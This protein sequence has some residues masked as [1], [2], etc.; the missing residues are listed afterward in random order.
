MPNENQYEIETTKTG[1]YT[2]FSTT[3]ERSSGIDLA[4]SP[5]GM[6]VSGHYDSFVGISGFTA[7]LSEVYEALLKAGF[8]PEKHEK[9][10][11]WPY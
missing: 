7:P 11:S 8:R 4:F 10:T 2:T 5:Y 1:K 9:P 3:D 6:S